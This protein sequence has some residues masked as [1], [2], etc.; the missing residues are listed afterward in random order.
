MGNTE[1]GKPTTTPAPTVKD[2]K[3]NVARIKQN[4]RDINILLLGSPGSGKSSTSNS[5]YRVVTDDISILPCP[6]NSQSVGRTTV[7][8]H[9]IPEL[10]QYRIRIIDSPGLG[11][12]H[13]KRKEKTEEEKEGKEKEEKEI[14]GKK[15]QK[16]VLDDFTAL[17][18]GIK[19]GTHY[20]QYQNPENVDPN[21]AIHH[22]I[23]VVRSSDMQNLR[24][25]W[26]IWDFLPSAVVPR[27]TLALN[28]NDK[29]ERIAPFSE[30]LLEVVQEITGH[31]PFIIVTRGSELVVPV[32]EMRKY[33]GE[34]QFP[35]NDIVFV[36]NY[37]SSRQN[38]NIKTDEALS[39]ALLTILV[40]LKKVKKRSEDQ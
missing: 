5:I 26:K 9:P 7:R 38:C 35:T 31:H 12:Q 27:G 3:T 15:K 23:L 32:E 19:D 20:D 28:E 4:D 14:E 22:V 24:S 8:V 13:L 25:G 2:I 29:L 11:M 21:N 30:L 16:S 33:L 40:R 39:R 17:L 36:E 1:V 10:E 6:T 34:S 37:T 18:H